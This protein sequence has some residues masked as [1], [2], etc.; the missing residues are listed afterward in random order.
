MRSELMRGHLDSLLLA[1]LA[2]APGHG[3]EITQRL[4]SASGGEIVPTEG[5]I[6]PALHRLERSRL[7]TSEW[8]TGEGR[9]RRV[10]ALTKRGRT[11]MA[12]SRREWTAFSGAVDRIM[13]LTA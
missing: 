3:Y 4:A 6:Y 2:S 12:E 10:Y 8:S 1:A 7:V 13:G 11:A 5:S 9:R